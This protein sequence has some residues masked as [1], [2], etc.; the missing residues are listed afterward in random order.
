VF[1]TNQDKEG[2]EN[3]EELPRGL[4][5]AG[6]HTLA[7]NDDHARQE[8]LERALQDTKLIIER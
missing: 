4:L 5:I 3:V 2:L 7:D 1:L 6:L 8:R